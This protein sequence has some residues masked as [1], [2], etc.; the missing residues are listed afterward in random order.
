MKKIY[1]GLLLVIIV[2]TAS[3]FLHN[4]LLDFIEPLTIGILLGM[5]IANT[6]GID[7]RFDAGITFAYKKILKWGIVLLGVKLNFMLIFEMGPR[8]FFI[9]ITLISTALI[10]SFL[11]GRSQNLNSRLSVLL[12]V[13][14]SI[15]GASA[16]MTMGP[17]IGA[18]D[19][20][21]ALSVTA[22][23]LLGAVGVMI[24][25]FAGCKLPISD[26]QYGIWSGS[27]LQGVS[28][29]LAAASARGTD[30][31][32]LE[33]GTI[34]KMARVSLLGPVALILVSIFSKDSNSHKVRFPAYVL[35]FLITGMFFTINN[36]FG[37]LPM[38]FT[39]SGMS[40][41]IVKSLKDLSSFFILMS[42]VAMGMR[43]NLKSFES[44]ALKT[45]GVCGMVF[46]IVSL[47]SLGLAVM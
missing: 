34:V 13:G 6:A 20:D 37:L 35:L 26:I 36:K 24:F 16:I 46:M 10:S 2:S 14:S 17:V 8:I 9:I 41:D 18:E 7:K 12:G 42:M 3:R 11:I 43:V 27:S 15:C 38:E 33:I 1:K 31:I 39:F 29:A 47:L 28:H 25:S 19:E 21:I 45:I 32:S 4:H 40:F 23:S 44:K 22:I 30:C 5:V